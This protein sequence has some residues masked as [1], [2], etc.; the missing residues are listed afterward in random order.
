M[1]HTAKAQQLE[2]TQRYIHARIIS[3]FYVPLEASIFIVVFLLLFWFLCN[4]F[5]SFQWNNYLY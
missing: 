4:V 3:N 5:C 1:K 2:S